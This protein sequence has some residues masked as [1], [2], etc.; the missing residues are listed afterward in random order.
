MPRTVVNADSGVPGS[1]ADF[2]PG[3]LRVAELYRRRDGFI[4]SLL[5]DMTGNAS[6]KP[7]APSGWDR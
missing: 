6:G 4:R 2:E 7:P 1:A 3:P 5:S